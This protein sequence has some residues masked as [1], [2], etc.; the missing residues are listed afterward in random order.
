MKSAHDWQETFRYGSAVGYKCKHCHNSKHVSWGGGWP[1]MN[2]FFNAQGA[3]L[4]LPLYSEPD[5]VEFPVGGLFNRVGYDPTA[6]SP[7]AV[8]RARREP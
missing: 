2:E 1:T 8:L 6:P 4:K 7:N 3:E 5:C